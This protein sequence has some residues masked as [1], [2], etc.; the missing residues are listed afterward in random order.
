MKGSSRRLRHDHWI[1]QGQRHS[2]QPWDYEQAGLS[3]QV[4]Y[5]LGRLLIPYLL[6]VSDLT[7][8]LY[9]ENAPLF[10]TC[11][12]KYPTFSFLVRYRLT[13]DVPGTTFGYFALDN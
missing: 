13:R 2:E 6:P 11:Y 9:R 10:H 3:G 12:L 7:H 4:S 8:L 1:T 5:F